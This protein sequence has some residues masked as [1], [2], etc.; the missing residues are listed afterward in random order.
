MKR[1]AIIFCGFALLLKPALANKAVIN[2]DLVLEI[3][4]KKIFPIGFTLP[5]PPDGKTPEGKSG[6]GELAAAGA[7]FLRTGGPWSEAAIQRERKYLDAAARYGMHCL[8][9][10]PEH[11]AIRSATAEAHL[12]KLVS[13]VK[14]H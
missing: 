3:D 2:S 4:G 6:I 5:P 13:R 8:P 14:H 12:R 10:L 1:T 9:Y 11:A 7:T